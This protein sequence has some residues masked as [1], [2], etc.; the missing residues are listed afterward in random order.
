MTVY[1]SKNIIIFS[2]NAIISNWIVNYR[3][4]FWVGFSL[5][6]IYYAS[7]EMAYVE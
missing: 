1:I 2:W 5:L 6:M 3:P 4:S 7:I